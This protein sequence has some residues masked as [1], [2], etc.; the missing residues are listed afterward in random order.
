MAHAPEACF[1][2]KWGHH[3][4][5]SYISCIT[6][7]TDSECNLSNMLFSYFLSRVGHLGPTLDTVMGFSSHLPSNFPIHEH[8]PCVVL[9]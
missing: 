3:M 1:M 8:F 2:V 5:I 7:V 6:A 4:K 9:A